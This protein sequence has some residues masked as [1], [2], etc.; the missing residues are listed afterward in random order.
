MFFGIARKWRILMYQRLLFTAGGGIISPRQQAK[1]NEAATILIGLGGTGIDCLRVLKK[2]IFDRLQPDDSNSPYP[3]YQ[4]IKFLA[5]DTD[6]S[7]LADNGAIDAL[8]KDTEFFN[9]SS[10]IRPLLGSGN[11]LSE[12]PS[13]RWFKAPS[14]QPEG[15]GIEIGSEPRDPVCRVRQIGRL[16]LMLKSQKF[17]AKL[18]ALITAAKIGLSPA[19]PL[20]IHIFTGICGATGGGT[21][22]DVCYLVQYALQQMEL[23]GEAQTCGFFFL[24]DV[25]LSNPEWDPK[26]R[27]HVKSNG[28]A[29]MKELDHCMNFDINGDEW[30]QQYNGFSIR[31]D[32]RPVDLAFLLSAT[33]VDG[34]IPQ[35]GYQYAMQV[36]ADFVITTLIK[37]CIDLGKVYPL[38]GVMAANMHA[39][40]AAIPKNHGAGY[41]YCLIGASNVYM[42]YKSINTYLVSKIFEGFGNLR[43][44]VPTKQDI[45][46]FLKNTNL[47]L[48]DLWQQVKNDLP[49][50]PIL[51]IDLKELYND[52]QG[53]TD[54]LVVPGIFTPMRRVANEIALGILKRNRKNM[55]QGLEEVTVGNA[56]T[57]SSLI[58]RIRAELMRIAT[59][60]D[61]GPY[62]AGAILHSVKDLDI[63]DVLSGYLVEARRKCQNAKIDL[64]VRI[65]E[66]KQALNKFQRSNRI[67]RRGA[68]KNY[69]QAVHAYFAKKVEIQTYETLGD[70]IEQLQQQVDALYNNFFLIFDQVMQELERTFAENLKDLSAWNETNTYS[71][72]LL[73]ISDLKESLDNTVKNMRMPNLIAGFVKYMLEHEDIWYTRDGYKIAAGVSAYFLGILG[74]YTNLTMTDYLTI[75][76][77]TNIPQELANHVLNDILI[78]QC[79]ANSAP[80]FWLNSAFSINSVGQI[81][82]CSIPNGSS[83]IALATQIYQQDHT[84]VSIRP[85]YSK[86]RISILKI[87]FGI[88]MFAYKGAEE[89][90]NVP[91]AIGTYLYEGAV[92]D[93][94]D[95]RK[96][97]EIRPYSFIPINQRSRED[98]QRAA[99]VDQA[100][101]KGLF[102]HKQKDD[103]SS[104]YELIEL[105][106][107][108]M[109]QQLS[110]IKQAIESGDLEKIKHIKNEIEQNLYPGKAG[111]FPR[112]GA[113]GYEDMVAKDLL[114]ALDDKTSHFEKDIDLLNQRD[115]LLKES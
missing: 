46:E 78:R 98:Q 35:N 9:I 54:P 44:Q 77:G 41:R 30:N 66:L 38:L 79:E 33:D 85:S 62:F 31:T 42:P 73:T 26:I 37:P 106:A 72:T 108:A 111:Y 52:V 113:K 95:W 40:L 22:L 49:A 50:V 91:S 8:N 13:L 45:T 81:G 103:P 55:L 18:D 112:T 39:M 88:P 15:T 60:P 93:P 89:Y 11:V 96:L 4:H 10:N 99:I 71:K 36:T 6:K 74:S 114:I 21:F 51:E 48:E 25:N 27:E 90:R 94:R 80:L 1:Q 47:T 101:E 58:N 61:R 84:Q 75:K 65:T 100:I 115:Q 76:Y 34:H 56:N 67:N 32:R 23:D 68:A 107:S 102:Y 70:V 104:D 63:S 7:S 20:N 86:D 3:T 28:Y 82:L 110:L 14:T 57:A 17:V 2:E 109:E 59:Q 12:D 69:L 64:S 105:D 5:V 16:L 83:I 97:R 29:S 24:P 87:Q 19:A 92:G 43:H 53:I